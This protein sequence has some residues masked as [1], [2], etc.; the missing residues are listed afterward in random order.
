MH[1]FKIFGRSGG[2]VCIT[3]F[4]KNNLQRKFHLLVSLIHYRNRSERSLFDILIA[5][6]LKMWGM[7]YYN[8]YLGLFD[9]EDVHCGIK[10]QIPNPPITLFFTF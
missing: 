5:L 8:I 4:R 2:S 7:N 3:A 9:G 10:Y 1:L 6:K